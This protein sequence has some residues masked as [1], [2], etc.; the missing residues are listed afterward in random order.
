M[1]MTPVPSHSLWLESY[2]VTQ[3]K[4]WL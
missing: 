4:S 2:R 3:W 1:T